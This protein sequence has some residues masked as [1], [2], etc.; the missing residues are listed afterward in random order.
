MIEKFDRT[1]L[2]P[3]NEYRKISLSILKRFD[4][5]CR[6][7]DIKYTL[8]QGTLLGAVRHK[9]F[10]PWDDDIDIAVPR[11]DFDKIL[12]L[13]DRLPDEMCFLNFPDNPEFSRL[14]GRICDM[15]YLNVDKYYSKKY[16]HYFGLDVFPVE[17]VPDDDE[18][19]L[20]LAKKL[21]RL[22][23]MFI[24]SNSAFFK[25][26]SFLKAFVIKPPLMLICKIIGR[27]RIYKMFYDALSSYDYDNAHSVA[28]VTG[29]YAP[30]EK[31]PK[32]IYDN[33]T[34]IEYENGKYFAVGDYNY[35]L[36]KIYGDYMELPPEKDRVGH[37]NFNIYKIM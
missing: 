29:A 23:S 13:K 28:I 22:R 30:R 34:E 12:S 2:V 7:N 10:I 31:M 6:E 35:Y 25:G 4:K 3:E 5:F 33:L 9:G 37:H 8:T 32:Q 1:A 19:Y 15:N 24:L 36:E 17:A 27:K 11:P 14:Y 20:R 21:S 26:I 16:V 18:E